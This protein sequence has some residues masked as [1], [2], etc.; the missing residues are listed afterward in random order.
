VSG[1]IPPRLIAPLVA[2]GTLVLL[3]ALL[4][5][6]EPLREALQAAFRGDT[7][8]MR[9]DLLALGL[10]GAV[11][12]FLLVQ[13]HTVV[14]Y[15]AEIVLVVAGYV[16]GIP[17]GLALMVLAWATSGVCC[18]AL[19]RAIG[20]PV[21][22]AA[23]GASQ[24]D[25]LER[26]LDRQGAFPLLAARL[27]PVVPHALAGYVAG[28]LRVPIGRFAWTTV[29][30]YLPL[31][32][33]VVVLGHRLDGLS[34]TDPLLWGAVAALLAL[35]VASRPLLRRIERRHHAN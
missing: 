4:L 2:A 26:L 3:A 7:G 23:F 15:P 17:V 34:P 25:A 29:V 12:L 5:G 28:A 21:L 11:V 1:G 18:W 14:F 8:R 32:A 22:R 13:V 30:G 27:I 16:Y 10:W 6:V 19:G 31:Q 20:R 35:L 9:D 24:I 33:T